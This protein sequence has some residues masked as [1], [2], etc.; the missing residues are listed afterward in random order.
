VNAGEGRAL[1]ARAGGVAVAAVAL[2]FVLLVGGWLLFTHVPTA[3]TDSVAPRYS[4]PGIGPRQRLCMRGLTVPA[5]ANAIRLRL[6]GQEGA[7]TSVT[8]RL[9]AGGRTQVSHSLAPPGGFGGEFHFAALGRDAPATAC[10]TTS[11]TLVAESGMPSTSSGAGVASIGRKPIGM[12][13]LSY[14]RLPSQRLVSALPAGAHRASLFRAGIVGA[15]TYWVLA[16][17]I[18]AAWAAG[19]RLVLRGLA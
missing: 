14:L 4:L 18:M 15:W 19:L 10:L 6:A 13:T 8:L 11:R 2:L 12:L 1:S 7:R 3:G 17:L 16:A 9:A 5:W